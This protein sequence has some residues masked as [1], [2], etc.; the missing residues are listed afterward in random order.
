M[1]RILIIEDN[2]D[3]NLMLVKTLKAAGYETFS[4]YTGIEGRYG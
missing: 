1:D 4:A 3:L 2:K